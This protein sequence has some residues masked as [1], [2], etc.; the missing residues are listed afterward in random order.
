MK[1]THIIFALFF[2]CACALNN[3]Y[4]NPF[5]VK[6]YEEKVKNYNCAKLF[7]EEEYINQ[8]L[9]ALENQIKNSAF[10]SFMESFITIGFQT[11]HGKKTLQK[12][13][14][15][16][17]QKLKIIIANQKNKSCSTKL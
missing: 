7:S 14:E 8:N 1:K 6:N 17:D 12:S 13:K 5:E 15:I 11:N 10:D 16:F 3:K 9:A 4:T 2:I